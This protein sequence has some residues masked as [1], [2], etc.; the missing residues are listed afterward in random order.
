M[1]LRDELDIYFDVVE[2][3]LA[4]FKAICNESDVQ[5]PKQTLFSYLQNNLK[6]NF[7]KT[8]FFVIMANFFYSLFLFFLFASLFL[9][10]VS[11]VN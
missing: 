5:W 9:E 11:L 3:E 7:K 1:S 6:N 4:S 2:F 10:G 8:I